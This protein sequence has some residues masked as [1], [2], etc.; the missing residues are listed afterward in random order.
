MASTASGT[1]TSGFIVSKGGG[2]ILDVTRHHDDRVV[3]D[4]RRAAA[5]HLIEEHAQRIQVAARIERGAL[6]LLGRHVARSAKH[7]PGLGLELIDLGLVIVARPL[8]DA[9]IKD[10]A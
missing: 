7:G 2:R 6:G 5:Q 10:F 8:G 1:F 9:E 3:I 4:E